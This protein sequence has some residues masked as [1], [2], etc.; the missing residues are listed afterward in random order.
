MDLKSRR[1]SGDLIINESPHIFG[2]DSVKLDAGAAALTITDRDPIGVFC[3]DDGTIVLAGSEATLTGIVVESQEDL[4]A[5]M[6][7][8][9][10]TT[11]PYAVLRRG[12]VVINKNAIPA[13]DPQGAAFNVATIVTRLEALGFKVLT[14]PTATSTQT[15]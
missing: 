2:R 7:A 12:E 6:A 8:D 5:T 3:T 4:P 13:A 14:N 9:A 15:T 10:L 1:R 11:M